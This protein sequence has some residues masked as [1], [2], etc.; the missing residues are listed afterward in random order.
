MA[1]AIQHHPAGARTALQS[2][3]Y[4]PR[5]WAISPNVLITMAVFMGSP[6]DA[7]IG[8]AG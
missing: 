5:D 6:R 3:Q 4:D 7:G 8:R 2:V 1:A